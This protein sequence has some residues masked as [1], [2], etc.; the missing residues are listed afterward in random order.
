MEK[1]DLDFLDVQRD[2]AL[3]CWRTNFLNDFDRFVLIAAYLVNKDIHTHLA[4]KHDCIT[5]PESGS[6]DYYEEMFPEYTGF[7][8]RNLGFIQGV[9]D[10]FSWIDTFF[11]LNNCLTG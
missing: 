6:E 11:F 2:P 10:Y 1:H 8:D 9:L 3:R 7:L 5:P 4:W